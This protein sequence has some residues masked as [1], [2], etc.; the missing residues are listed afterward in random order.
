MKKINE[1]TITALIGNA[2]R[3]DTNLI[4]INSSSENVEE[5][6]SLGHLS[7]LESL[8]RHFDGKV[9]NIIE[10]ASSNSVKKILSILRKNSLL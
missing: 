8:D 9:A 2:L 7:I 6:D 1:E 5:W 10:L 3:I 4:S